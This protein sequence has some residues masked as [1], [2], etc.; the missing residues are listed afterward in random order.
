M[1]SHVSYKVLLYKLQ[2]AW[3]NSRFYCPCTHACTHTHTHTY[4]L[5]QACMEERIHW[6]KT[7]WPEGPHN[8]PS[9]NITSNHRQMFHPCCRG[10]LSA[11]S[12]NCC[13]AARGSHQGKVC[14]KHPYYRAFLSF[15]DR[16]HSSPFLCRCLWYWPSSLTTS[17]FEKGW[18]CLQVTKRT[19]SDHM[20]LDTITIPIRTISYLPLHFKSFH[21]LSL[22]SN[23]DPNMKVM[24]HEAIYLSYIQIHFVI[25]LVMKWSIMDNNLAKVISGI[26]MEPSSFSTTMI[27]DESSK[28]ETCHHSNNEKNVWCKMLQINWWNFSL[29]HISATLTVLLKSWLQ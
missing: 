22:W 10:A 12:N 7:R 25:Y 17:R 11:W 21:T 1:G 20:F 26:W 2:H 14:R 8:G 5:L 9:V 13:H 23:M 18:I 19:F 29:I 16:S 6:I 28:S 15:G 27:M 3:I 24:E 4:V